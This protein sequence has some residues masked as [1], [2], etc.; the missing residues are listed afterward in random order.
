MQTDVLHLQNSI[1]VSQPSASLTTSATGTNVNCFGNA[2][3][4]VSLTVNGGTGPYSYAW[5][6]GATTQNISNIVAGNYTV[7]V[8]DANGCTSSQNAISITQPSAALNSSVAA[9]QNI[10]CFGSGTGAINIAVSGGTTPYSFNWSNGATTQNLTN[11][12]SGTYSVT[13]TDAKG[14]TSSTNNITLSQPSAAISANIQSMQNVSCNGGGN[15]AL[16]LTVAGGTAPYTYLWSNGATTQNINGLSSGIYNVT[17][18]D[19]KGCELQATGT[20][21]QPANALSA[22][23]SSSQNVLCFGGNNAHINLSVSGGY[24]TLFIYLE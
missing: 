13:I 19:S 22:S 6:N 9:T 15:G 17:I 7:T 21:S 14:C 10:N 11:L 2:T 8:T 3:G 18:T 5:S 12:A 20:V 16:N 23:I 1:N 24:F 4:A